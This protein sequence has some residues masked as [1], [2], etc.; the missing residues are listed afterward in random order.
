MSSVLS[1]NL[2]IQNTIQYTA[3]TNL[4]LLTQ[5]RMLYSGTSVYQ[6]GVSTAITIVAGTMY[7]AIIKTGLVLP[8][9]YNYFMVTVTNGDYPAGGLSII[10]TGTIRNNGNGT[11]TAGMTIYGIGASQS[12]RVNW[13]IYAIV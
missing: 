13:N 2:V 10:Y 6:T 11:Y 7:Y 5:P 8:A 4:P 12:F 1:E 9:G 3:G